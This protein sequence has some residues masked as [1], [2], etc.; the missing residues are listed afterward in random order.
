MQNSDWHKRFVQQARWTAEAQSYLLRRCGLAKGRRILEVGCGTGAV[1]AA[2]QRFVAGREG[3]AVGVLEAN[4]PAEA[5]NPRRGEGGF[6]ADDPAEASNPGERARQGAIPEPAEEGSRPGGGDGVFAADDRAEA[7]NPR[8][9]AWAFISSIYERYRPRSTP[10][11]GLY[12][13]DLKRDFLLLAN[14]HA[15]GAVLTQGDA[16]HLPY[17]GSVFDG[18]LCHFFLLWVNDPRQALDEMRR[19]TRPGGWVLALAEPDYGG[20]IDYPAELAQ[21]GELQEE[22]LRRQG[23]DTRLGRS[24]KALF[25]QAGLSEIETGILGGQWRGLPPE[26]E[27]AQ[28]WAVLEADLDGLLP[29]GELARLRRLDEAAWQAGERVLFVPTFYAAG[30]K[31]A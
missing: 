25:Q 10:G 19:V 7:S 14:R 23:A 4:E 3:Q 31:A 8:G 5:L 11:G 20:R 22:A 12:G 16:L 21:L 27:R 24:L 13:L 9:R 2:V 30:R 26:E 29:P 28:E 6:A 17:A 1:L 18:T 15:P